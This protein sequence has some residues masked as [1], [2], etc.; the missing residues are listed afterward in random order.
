MPRPKGPHRAKFTLRMDADILAEMAAA[1]KRS[2]R[3]TND[4]MY[5]ALL[6]KL[7]AELREE[8]RA[9]RRQATKEERQYA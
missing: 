6:E 3:N 2:G 1:A 5:R 9:I 7:A 4:W 8:H